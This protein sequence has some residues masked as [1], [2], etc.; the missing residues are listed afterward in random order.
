MEPNSF[1]VPSNYVVPTNLSIILFAFVYECLLICDA[2][3]NQNSV[4]VTAVCFINAGLVVTTALSRLQ[5][6]N[7]I[8]SMADARDANGQPLVHLDQDIWGNVREIMIASPII[9]AVGT[10]LLF[11]ILLK[12]LKHFS[13][14]KYQHLNGDLVMR[15]RY[16]VYQVNTAQT[17]S[18][19]CEL[20]TNHPRAS[21]PSSKSTSS[22]S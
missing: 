13:W 2:I 1:Q 4:Q 16:L 11:A 18:L 15:R 12:L 17:N 19:H 5:L 3:Y 7:A 14:I 20:A 22:W 6:K 8:Y 21:S 9:L 10:A